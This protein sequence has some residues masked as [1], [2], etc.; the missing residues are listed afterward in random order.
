MIDVR[1][2][3]AAAARDT[4][5]VHELA[6]LLVAGAFLLAAASM[7]GGGGT[8]DERPTMGRRAGRAGLDKSIASL[9]Q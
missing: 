3:P 4:G 9:F 7:P 8:V 1:I 5:L 6:G 2:G